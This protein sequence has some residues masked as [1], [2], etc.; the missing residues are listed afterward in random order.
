VPDPDRREADAWAPPAHDLLPSAALTDAAASIER[1]SET[2]AAPPGPDDPVLEGTLRAPWRWERLLVDAAV[3]G[4]AGRW[5]R[6]LD[7]LAA[8]LDLQRGDLPEEDARSAALAR[9]ARDLEHLRAFALPII[10]RL[11][12]LPRSATWGVWLEHLRGLAQASIR[13]PAHVLAVLAELEPLAPVGPAELSDVEHVLAPRLRDLTVD[14]GHRPEGA[15]TVAP[16]EIARGLAFEVVFV[17]G[18]AEKVFPP[19]II[20]DPLLPDA[21]RRT[22]APGALAIQADR[23]AAERLALR[24]AAGAARR[25]LALSW[26][27]LDLERG[28]PRV[29]SFYGPE[30][31]RAAEG[32][33]PGFDELRRRAESAS[34]T[35]PGWPAPERAEDA[36]DDSE[37]DLSVL[38]RFEGAS[39]PERGAAR[40]LLDVPVL[41]RALRARAQRWT[42]LWTS[43]D[44]LVAPHEKELA[45]ESGAAAAEA[46]RLGMAA[47][48]RH[49]M[50]ARSFSPTALENFSKCPYR[51]VLQAIQRLRPREEA[52]AL[53]SIDPL[54]RGSFFHT[55]QFEVLTALRDEGRLPLDPARLEVAIERLDGTVKRVAAEWKERLAPAIDRV[56]E[57][58]VHAIRADLREW[59]RRAAEGADGWVPH[60][61]ELAFGL[62]ERRRPTE[63]VGSVDQPV[64]V[65]GDVLLRGSIDLVERRADGTLRVTDHKTGK[66]RAPEG[67]VVGGGQYLQP[68]LYALVAEAVLA[69]PVESG[70]LYYCTADGDFQERVIP[71]DEVTRTHAKRA[72]DVVRGA[73]DEGFLPALP[74]EG[75]CLWCDYRLVCGPHEE[76]RTRR[77]GRERLAAIESLRSLP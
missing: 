48:E 14:P 45:R 53:E 8:E 43:S 64:A 49:K 33:L 9:T 27:R 17:P 74:A 69:A 5:R 54:T 44:G 46:H 3:I 22:L 1:A 13:H 38:G 7:G 39:E 4:G 62:A 11:D 51:F 34:R 10:E 37:Y 66:A 12:E 72:T 28:R 77:K 73:I 70:R 63:D 52:E 6:R 67:A 25:H 41:G 56:W 57:D 35:R 65:L 31:L 29:P 2:G 55:V 76:S 50:G 26:P 30:A 15:V 61:F 16:I 18:L 24:I 47:L 59:L 75:E 40:Y 71:L 60:R 20:E 42:R 36:I 21:L 58:G 68:A 32:R 23:V 19:Q